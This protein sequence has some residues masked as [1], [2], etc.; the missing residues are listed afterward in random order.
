[1]N[2][3]NSEF[4]MLVAAFLL[5]YFFQEMMK[6][7][8]VVEGGPA[9][10][11]PGKCDNT[12]HPTSASWAQCYNQPTKN[13]CADERSAILN[14]ITTDHNIKWDK[15]QKTW[16]A[17]QAPSESELAEG[18]DPG[19]ELGSS[20]KGFM[21]CVNKCPHAKMDALGRCKNENGKTINPYNCNPF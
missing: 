10:S 3:K 2:F 12:S 8:Q 19:D 5:G 17:H 21:S 1:M 20:M 15:L 16:S 4:L 13:C 14:Q 9:T 18:C 11:S 7:C 6:G